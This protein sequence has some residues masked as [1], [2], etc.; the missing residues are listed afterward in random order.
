M[1][2]TKVYFGSLLFRYS[3]VELLVQLNRCSIVELAMWQL[4]TFF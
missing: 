4:V 2:L 1:L 3:N